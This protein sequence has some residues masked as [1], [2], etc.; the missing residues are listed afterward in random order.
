MRAIAAVFLC[1]MLAA[2]AGAS[3]FPGGGSEDVLEAPGGAYTLRLPGGWT[4]TQRGGGEGGRVSVAAH[5]DAAA[6]G[7]GY[8]TLVVKEVREP[9]AQGVMDIMARDKNLEFSGLWTVTPD[10]YQLRQALLDDTSRVLS[11]WLAPR[12]GQGL[13]YYACVHLTRSGR[14]EM[15][16]VAQAG[17]VQKYM[18]DFNLMFTSLAIADKDRFNPSAAADTASSLRGIYAREVRNERDGLER[19]AAETASW[20]TEPGMTTQERGFLSGAY[21]RAVAKAMEESGR[22]LDC[23]MKSHGGSERGEFS[24]LAERLDETA[25]SVETIQ[26]NMRDAKARLSVEKSAQR[27]RRMARLAREAAKL[28]F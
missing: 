21:V 11:F 27:M 15:I 6:T 16:G 22:L 10:K 13:E 18:K 19:Q 28:P 5:R 9:A 25:T 2:C 26:L 17:T 20:A 1:L 8:P 7:K 24:R 12:D 14:I 23:V 4:V 3:P